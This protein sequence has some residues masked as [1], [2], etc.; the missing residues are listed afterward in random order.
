MHPFACNVL[1]LLMTFIYVVEQYSVKC[2]TVGSK[3]DMDS[4]V[5]CSIFDYQQS[6]LE[7]FVRMEMRVESMERYIKRLET[8]TKVLTSSLNVY[9]NETSELLQNAGQQLKLDFDAKLFK[10]DKQLKKHNSTFHSITHEREI[11]KQSVTEQWIGL[12]S[13]INQLINVQNNSVK[14]LRHE[15][16]LWK[17]MIKHN[18]DVFR[19]FMS[20]QNL[21]NEEHKGNTKTLL[22]NLTKLEK[23]FRKKSTLDRME[24]ATAKSIV[25]MATGLRRDS[26]ISGITLQFNH[27]LINAGGGYNSTNGVFTAPQ[28][29]IYFFMVKMSV[30]PKKIAVLKIKTG[31]KDSIGILRY[32][33][34]GDTY[35]TVSGN[36]IARLSK[37]EQAYVEGGVESSSGDVLGSASFYTSF[38]GFLV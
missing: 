28:T 16:N 6:L 37:D 19:H 29:G 25:F 2:V 24:Q 11:F 9:K 15:R 8:K 23:K 1:F 20:K 31:T 36:G 26:D 33:N 17:Q 32:K 38:S 14:S 35:E 27:V 13:T 22:T 12:N 4:S 18:M 30:E 21:T 7:K 10:I 5:K 3:Q 34:D